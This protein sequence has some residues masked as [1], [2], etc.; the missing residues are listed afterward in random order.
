MCPIKWSSDWTAYCNVK[1]TSI[2]K[3]KAGEVSVETQRHQPLG[4]LSEI[5][6]DMQTPRVIHD[7]NFGKTPVEHHC[8]NSRSNCCC[9]IRRSNLQAAS[10]LSC[11]RAFTRPRRQDCPCTMTNTQ[12]IRA[13]KA[14]DLSANMIQPWSTEKRKSQLNLFT[15]ITPNNF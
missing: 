4:P 3:G 11:R 8:H 2:L 13:K 10:L 6:D 5:C 12:Q 14:K 9:I 15:L 1:M 7:F